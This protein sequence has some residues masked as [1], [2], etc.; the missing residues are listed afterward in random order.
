MN[1]ELSNASDIGKRDDPSDGDQG[2]T[3]EEDLSGDRSVRESLRN[4]AW[5]HGGHSY[6]WMDSH[7]PSITPDLLS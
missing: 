4:W 5:A 2:P 7:S 1:F 6:D 3:S